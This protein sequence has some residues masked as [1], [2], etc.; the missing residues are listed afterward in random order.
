MEDYEVLVYEYTLYLLFDMVE[1][2]DFGDELSR[3]TVHK[4][5]TDSLLK[6]TFHS[7]LLSKMMGI[8]VQLHNKNTYELSNEICHLVSEIREPLVS[9]E[10]TDDVK[11][12]YEFEVK[13]IAPNEKMFLFVFYYTLFR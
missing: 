12:N 2:Y 13:I 3:K 11:R 7:K 6:Y 10:P 4:L 9:V 1:Q 8:L 5:I